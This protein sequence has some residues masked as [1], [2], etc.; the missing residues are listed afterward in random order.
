MHYLISW[1][2]SIYRDL[3]YFITLILQKTNFNKPIIL[4]SLGSGNPIILIHGSAGSQ[5][6]WT[7]AINHIK[8]YLL[9]N[10]IYAFSL[11]LD[12]NEISNKQYLNESS[13]LNSYLQYKYYTYNLDHSVEHYV[14][15]LSKRINYVYAKHNKKII[16]IGHS[17][18]GIVANEYIIKHA[19]I[20]NLIAG[21]V[22]VASPLQGAPLLK[23]TNK[24]LNTKRHL[25]MTPGSIQL[26]GLYDNL[27][28]V[29]SLHPRL[30]IGSHQDIVVP[31]M[32][33]RYPVD[34]IGL[35]NIKHITYSNYGHST[36]LLNEDVWLQIA[37]WIVVF[38]T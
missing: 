37:T 27:K 26:N 32:Y 12:F 9:D 19:P 29:I 22:T 7:G 38:V 31:N 10:P 16:L 15:V 8:K 14:D 34:I 33:S 5:I 3:V 18:G 4:N 24:I 13:L 20:K 2:V 6:E 36:L 11:D 17:I 30:T 35:N 1:V 23:Y 21:I 28:N 25:Y